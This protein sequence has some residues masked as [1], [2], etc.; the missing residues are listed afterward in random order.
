MSYYFITGKYNDDESISLWGRHTDGSKHHFRVTGFKPHFYVKAEERVPQSDRLLEV[1]D[2]HLRGVVGLEPLKKLIMKAP[3]DVGGVHGKGGFRE[4]FPQTWEADVDFIRRLLI[5]T[6]IRSGF[7][8]LVEK[9][10]IHYSDL[11]SS[12]SLIKSLYE[13]FLDVETYGIPREG[14]F[15][16]SL[17]CCCFYDYTNKKY[18]S[19]LVSRGKKDKEDLSEDHILYRVP[20]EAD[21]I[22][23]L[24]KY[25]E[26]N[27]PD[28]LSQWSMFDTDTVK[29]RA[30]F[31]KIDLDVLHSICLFDLCRA[32]RKL[33]KK[34]SNRL[35][36]VAF[37][38]EIIDYVEP[39]VD[40]AKMYDEDPMG[41]V[42]RNKH[43]VEWMVKINQKKAGGDLV[44]F[45]WGL[46]ARAGLENLMETLYHGVLVDTE[47]FRK[48]HGKY[49]LPTKRKFDEEE[50]E[51]LT[52]GLVKS[53]PRGLYPNVFSNPK[54]KDLEV[55]VLDMSRYYPNIMIAYNLTPEPVEQGQK[56]LVPELEEE[57][58]EERE[59]IERLLAKTVIDSE[60]Y[61]ALKS[62]RDSVKFI[63]E[64]VTGYYGSPS[65]RLYT[66]RIYEKV[67]STGRKGLLYLE[68]KVKDFEKETFGTQ[69]KI[70]VLYYDTD[71]LFVYGCPSNY[72]AKIVDYLNNSMKDFGKQEG[73]NRDLKLKCDRVANRTLFT[74]AK[75]RYC[76]RIRWEDGKDCDYILIKGFEN[77]RQ[78]ASII[79]R[80][81]QKETFKAILH[82]DLKG[83]TK[84]LQNLAQ[85]FKNKQFA[86]KDIAIRKTTHQKFS[87][88]KAKVDYIKG[89][90][91]AN[92]YL[93]LNIR[94]GDSVKMLYVIRIPSH[95]AITDVICFKDEADLPSDIVVNWDKMLNRT[96]EMKVEDFLSIAGLNW[97]QIIG[98]KSLGE[99]FG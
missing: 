24:R 67:V 8:T 9:N 33:Y 53:P 91:N 3:Q 35:K 25:L 81:V 20:T 46:K 51:D 59:K 76:M 90:E 49:I 50:L 27:N 70:S 78:D 29:A 43:H 63:T 58:L 68:A 16:K 15:D 64:A 10:S 73:I 96:V 97:K 17:T 1:Q 31:L 45:Y 56:G 5:D 86:L 74:G 7:D 82:D 21:L 52:G 95:P 72:I 12:D 32:Y 26:W 42:I 22:D 34:G 47:H 75:K 79:T 85:S 37:E 93:G 65:S 28:T 92:K 6:G 14:K 48:Y 83:L 88:Y 54:D 57:L 30:R 41:L 39:E 84:Y 36:D 80:T 23:W 18:L 99:A 66:P 55:F 38:E 62:P 98:A 69:G 60:E 11:I 77:V 4:E 13:S 61:H 2:E 87:D 94:P 19:C 44:R 71:S 40:Y 89:I